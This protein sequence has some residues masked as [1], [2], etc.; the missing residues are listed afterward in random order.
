MNYEAKLYTDKCES[1]DQSD[2]LW[3]KGK[4]SEFTAKKL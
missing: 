4:F 2:V 3:Q 1:N